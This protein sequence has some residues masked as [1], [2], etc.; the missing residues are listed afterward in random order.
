MRRFATIPAWVLA[1]LLLLLVADGGGLPIGAA[2]GGGG[3]SAGHG[4]SEAVLVAQL[5]VLLLV[6]RLL[7]EV[8]LR[9][10]QP[11][12]MGM[13]MAGLVLGPS[14]LGAL[15]PDIQQALFPAVKEQHAMLDAISQLGVLLI[16]LMTGMETDL[17]LVRES[18]R[19]AISASICGI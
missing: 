1:A 4:P 10:K 6:G 18:S 14:C 9:L 13:L 5:L 3:G 2:E 7:G 17:Q 16:L 8:L 12:V 19:A 15:F 11:A